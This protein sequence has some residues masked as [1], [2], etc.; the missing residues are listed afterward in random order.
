[1]SNIKQ[2]RKKPVV[3]EAMRYEG[4]Q[5]VPEAEKF[6]GTDFVVGSSSYNGKNY[7]WA[8]V[9]IETLDGRIDISKGDCIIKGVQGEFYS[10]K[11]DIFEETY[12][13]V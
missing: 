12:E 10:C 11:P 4:V 5:S 8:V 6:V 13:Q 1:M 9:A 7:D 3:I 2:Y